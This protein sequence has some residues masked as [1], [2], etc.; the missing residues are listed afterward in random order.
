[1]ANCRQCAIHGVH[2]FCVRRVP[3]FAAL[4]DKELSHVASHIHQ[5]TYHK[6]DILFLEGEPLHAL[7]II[8]TGSVKAYK[9]TP[10]GREQILYLFQTGDF[11]GEQN[12]FENH[13]AS[14][15]VEAL[16]TVITCA[17]NRD[18]FQ[19]LLLE[20]PVIA[21]KTIEELSK[22]IAQLENTLKSLGVRSVDGRIAVLLMDY[23]ERFGTI[24]PEGVLIQLPLSREGIANQLGITRETV[25]RKLSRMENGGVIRT[26]GSKRILILDR[27]TLETTANQMNAI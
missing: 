27:Q 5:R 15:T 16:E 12:L 18:S 6:G 13:N 21:I 8:H 17:F 4:D 9:T 1:M 25:S 19:A 20:H 11:L 22:R 10:D 7:I 2:A 26:V 14:Y 24:V 3:V 23:A